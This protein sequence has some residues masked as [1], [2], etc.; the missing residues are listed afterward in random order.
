MK[1]NKM[2]QIRIQK[3]TLNMG[4]GQAGEK[5]DKA[6][7]LL[8]SITGRKPIQTKT[9]RRIPTWGLR[10]KL[11]IAC[12]VT[13]RK[14]KADEVLKRLFV[15]VDNK[16]NPKKFDEY[17]NFSFGI[18]EYIDIPNVDYDPEIGITGLEAA[19]TLERPGFRITKRKVKSRKI[20][21]RHRI[22]KEEAISFLREKYGITIGDES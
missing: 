21:S 19:V 9:M 16:I 12:K 17:G 18:P 5:L 13:L 22:T 15:A 7:K 11:P 20:P 8:N 14:Q 2:R 4:V 3:V 6:L 1:N 10:P